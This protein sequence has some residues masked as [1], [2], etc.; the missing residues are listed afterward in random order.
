MEGIV[1]K[2][3]SEGGAYRVFMREDSQVCILEGDEG[4]PGNRSLGGR[5]GTRRQWQWVVGGSGHGGIESRVSSGFLSFFY[6]Y[7]WGMSM[8]DANLPGKSVEIAELD[9]DGRKGAQ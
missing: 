1:V 7:V 5:Q 2:W 8:R 4:I 6:S 3:T 9:F